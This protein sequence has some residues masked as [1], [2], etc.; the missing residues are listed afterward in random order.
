MN[1]SDRK[2]PADPLR[3]IQECVRN[4]RVLWT[5]HVNIRL[6]GR[7]I[8][9]EA[10]LDAVASY[11]IIEAYPGDKYLPSYLV[12]GRWAGEVFHVL[13]AADAEG[14]KVRVVTAYQPSE[15]EWENDW[16]TRKKPQ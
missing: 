7:F 13:F 3:F 4:R 8:R 2:L 9:R 14:N 15:G 10:V 6:R 11:E 16:K 5:Y 1:L 12:L